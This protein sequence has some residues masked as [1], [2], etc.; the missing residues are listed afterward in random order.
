VVW[1]DG[2]HEAF[3]FGHSLRL[4]SEACASASSQQHCEALHPQEANVRASTASTPACTSQLLPP[5]VHYV[6]GG[7]TF[8]HRGVLFAGACGWWDWQY[9]APECEPS[10]AR[11]H[12]ARVAKPQCWFASLPGSGEPPIEE[13]VEALARQEFDAL[14]AAV[15]AGEQDAAVERIVIVTHT[16]PHRSLLQKGIYPVELLDAAFYGNS[17]ME[18]LVQ[19]TGAQK[20]KLWV[21]GH[22]HSGASARVGGVRYESNPRGRPDDFHRAVYAP[23]ALEV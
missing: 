14:S 20:V 21:Y 18:G 16:V 4:S 10:A 11:A 12:F 15:T 9:C 8:R 6:G 22:S 2:N 13:A 17:R 7:R 19:E 3:E 1:V 5:N 23:R